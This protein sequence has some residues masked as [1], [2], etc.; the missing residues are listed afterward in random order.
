MNHLVCFGFGFSAGVLAERLSPQGWRITGTS[1]SAEGVERIRARGFEAAHF[2]G[3]AQ[4]DDVA[5]ALET[6][7]H[8]LISAPPGDDGDP[9]LAHHQ[10]DIIAAAGLRW[11]GYL[12]TIGVYGDRGGAWVDETTPEAPSSERSKRRLA[13]EQSW[14]ALKRT[15]AGP[16]VQVF[17]LA[18]IYGPG[19]SAIDQL[20]AGRARRIVSPGQVF[21]RI[22][23][24]DIASTLAAAITT[25]GAH[26]VYNVTDDEPAPPQDVIGHAAKLLG[27]PAP[28]E[29]PIEEADLSPMAKSFYSELRRVRNDRIKKDLGVRLCYPTYREGLAAVL[30]A[31]RGTTR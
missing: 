26:T 12:S 27:V 20:R 25:D 23:V 29:V 31:S 15:A 3:T 14:L 19:R 21:N 28:P 18:G 16:E 24:D 5:A 2:D 9:V 17:R 13:A 4:S 8:L 30:A 7:S 10:A 6:A 1:R 11:I 22:H